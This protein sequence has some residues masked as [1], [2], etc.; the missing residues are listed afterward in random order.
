MWPAWLPSG[1]TQRLSGQAAMSP[2]TASAQAGLPSRLGSTNIAP[3][4]R[5]ER[6]RLLLVDHPELRKL[7]GIYPATALWILLVVCLQLLLALVL[8]P[9][10]GW[11]WIVALTWCIGAP[12]SH[13]TFVLIHECSHDLV[14]PTRFQNKILAIV[15]NLGQGIPSAIS[16]SRYHLYHHAFLGQSGRDPDLA[17][18]WELNFVGSSF[19][20]KSL[21]ICL[22]GI[23]QAL[24]PLAVR[25]PDQASDPLLLFNI[26]TVLLVDYVVWR[27]AGISALVYLL[28]ST[29]VSLGPHPLA[30]RWIAEHYLFTHN[31][32]TSSMYG[33]A[34]KL[35]FNMGFHVEHHDLPSVPWVHLPKLRRIAPE[36]Y[37][38]PFHRSWTGCLVRFLVDRRMSLG[39]RIYSEPAR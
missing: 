19:W 16:F 4:Q 29:L 1:L 33:W 18:E 8:V 2:V 38:Q 26:L 11:P 12:L 7:C 34:N 20:R 36:Y 25:R 39:S 17:P 9:A 31:Q 37:N 3:V 15:C 30:G 27:T 21:W 22:F 28:G 24:R 5:R 32:E 14:L 35:A 23:S 13:A 10:L 6:A